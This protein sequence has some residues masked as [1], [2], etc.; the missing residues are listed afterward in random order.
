MHHTRMRHLIDTR[1][2]YR[3]LSRGLVEKL[4]QTNRK[5]LV[6]LREYGDREGQY[7]SPSPFR[8][9]STAIVVAV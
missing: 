2:T 6:F 3:A 8:L 5:V 4:Y 1:K 7:S 9:S